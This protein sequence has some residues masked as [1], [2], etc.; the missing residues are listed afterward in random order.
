M[1]FWLAS[2]L[3][4]KALRCLRPAGSLGRLSVGVRVVWVFVEC[5]QPFF[6]SAK[7]ESVAREKRAEEKMI[8]LHVCV[9]MW[10]IDGIVVG[11]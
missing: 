9:A 10:C 1:L 2:S 6:W 3:I 7:A 8:V 5:E 4:V 11:I